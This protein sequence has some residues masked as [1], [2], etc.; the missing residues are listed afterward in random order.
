MANI[1]IEKE[2]IFLNLKST[3]KEEAIRLAGNKL[4]EAGYVADG[5]V[6]SML[7]REELLTTYMDYGV[8][9]P[10]G[11]RESQQLI[12]QSGIVFLQFKDGID[13]GNGNKAEILIASAGK[14]NNHLRILSGLA[15]LLKKP[16]IVDLF[17][18][19]ND[20]EVIYNELVKYIK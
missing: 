3:T 12:I 5:Y 13:F 18:S 17:V 4:L 19:T 7:H 14:G 2:N 20:E 15:T 10:H 8:A 6:E 16:E 9:I 1:A 11:D